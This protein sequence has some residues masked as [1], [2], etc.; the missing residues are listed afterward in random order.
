MD[1]FAPQLTTRPPE[2]L[3][4]KR[5]GKEKWEALSTARVLG[6]LG[7]CFWAALSHS[8][9]ARLASFF[10]NVDQTYLSGFKSIST[11]HTPACQF[12]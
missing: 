4:E 2:Y 11:V 7:C 3:K 1:Q 9:L 12:L 10:Y 6:R 8:L 5:N